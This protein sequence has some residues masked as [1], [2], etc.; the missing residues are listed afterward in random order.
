MQIVTPSI[1]P[2][3]MELQC[4]VHEAQSGVGTAA[5]N[6]QIIPTV[7]KPPPTEGN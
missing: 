6:V 3:F 1:L 4:R 7:I 2:G 5:A